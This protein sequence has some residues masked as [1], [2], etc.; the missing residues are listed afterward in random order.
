[1][2][3]LVNYAELTPTAFR[4]R[5][6]AAPIAYLPLGTL[7]WHGEHLPLG[8]DGLQAAGFFELLA[9]R[10]G[11]IVLPMLF[12]GPDGTAVKDGH[13]YYGMD[14][15]G[16]PEGA[17]EQLDGSAYWVDGGLFHSILEAILLQLRRAG[18][19]IVVAHGHGPSTGQF[20]DNIPRWKEEFSMELFV[21]WRR[22][23]SD[24]YGIQTDHGAANETSLMMA[25][26]PDLVHMEC[27]PPD[28][29][30]ALLAVGG[31]DPR[32]DASAERGRQ[33]LETQADRMAALLGEALRRIQA[34]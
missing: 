7:E 15:Y 26:H 19:R 31:A 27:L 11:G 2:T 30:A 20:R 17:P 32:T 34:P 22:D 25:L 29:N 4:Q 9:R 13:T 6:A 5:L 24:G 28:P 1:M 18:F 12:L 23:E 21:C 33:S 16:H 10:A 14:I 8:S 3:E